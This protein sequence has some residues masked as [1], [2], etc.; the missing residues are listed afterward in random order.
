MTAV[1][2]YADGSSYQGN[3]NWAAVR[4]AGF[5]GGAEKA[6]QGIS[7]TNPFWPAARAALLAEKPARSGHLVRTFTSPRATAP[8]RRTTSHRRPGASQDSSSG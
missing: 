5:G 6:T 4:K 1:T 7:Y 8:G 3:I 2:F